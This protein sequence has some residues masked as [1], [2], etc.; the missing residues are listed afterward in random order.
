MHPLRSSV[1]RG[2][3]SCLGAASSSDAGRRSRQCRRDVSPFP[4]AHSPGRWRS[5]AQDLT[6]DVLRIDA[7]PAT[8]ADSV[9]EWLTSMDIKFYENKMNLNWCGCPPNRLC[10]QMRGY[11]FVVAWWSHFLLI[12]NPAARTLRC[13]AHCSECPYKHA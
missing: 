4:L 12:R 2:L 13:T 10:W 9:R 8:S 5:G 6:K 7:I 11:L 1:V 3:A